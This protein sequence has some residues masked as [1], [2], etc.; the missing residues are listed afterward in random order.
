M[1]TLDIL[2]IA[3]LRP[4][5]WREYETL[6]IDRVIPALADEAAQVVG[7]WYTLREERHRA[8]DRMGMAGARAQSADGTS[9]VPLSRLRPTLLR[10]GDERRLPPARDRSLRQPVGD[11]LPHPRRGGVVRIRR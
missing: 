10:L 1:S 8:R 6:T 9:A 5:S 3:S 11:R 7:L 4:Q 2:V